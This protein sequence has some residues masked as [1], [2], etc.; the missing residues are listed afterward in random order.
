MFS[1]IFVNAVYA[2]SICGLSYIWAEK[3]LAWIAFAWVIGNLISGAFAFIMIYLY[4]HLPTPKE[5]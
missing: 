2:I 3:G 4:K 1:I 5:S